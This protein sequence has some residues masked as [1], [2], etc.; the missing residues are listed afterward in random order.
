VVAERMVVHRASRRVMER[1]GLLPGRIFH[2]DWPVRIPGDD[3]GDIEYALHLEQWQ[4]R[5]LAA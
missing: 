5:L 2:A 3:Y 1:A 4:R